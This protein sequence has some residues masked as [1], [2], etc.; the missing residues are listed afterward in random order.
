VTTAR[1]ISLRKTDVL[2]L[3]IYS[4]L[5]FYLSS[6]SD[7]APAITP[8]LDIPHV[9]KFFHATE[10]GVLGLLWFRVLRKVDFHNPNTV[11]PV[12]SILICLVYAVLDEFLQQ[13]VPNRMSSVGDLAADGIGAGLAVGIRQAIWRRGLTF[14]KE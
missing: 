14:A 7:P 5:I 10:Y 8:F 1:T 12:I 3:F 11:V 4:S 9:D 6:Q 2:T 13:F